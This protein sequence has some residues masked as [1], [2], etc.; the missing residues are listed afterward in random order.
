[1]SDKLVRLDIEDDECVCTYACGGHHGELREQ[2]E[3]VCT[4]TCQ[5]AQS[6]SQEDVQ[7]VRGKEYAL[8][9]KYCPGLEPTLPKYTYMSY[10]P[11]TSRGGYNIFA[12]YMVQGEVSGENVQPRRG[13]EEMKTVGQK[14]SFG[15]GDVSILIT[16]WEKRAGGG[17]GEENNGTQV[18]ERKERRVSQ[19]FQELRQKFVDNEE[20]GKSDLTVMPKSG[21]S[22]KHSNFSTISKFSTTQGRGAVRKICFKNIT[23]SSIVGQGGASL[24]GQTANRKRKGGELEE[25]KSESKR[26]C[27]NEEYKAR[28]LSTWT[29]Y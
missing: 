19:E 6:H 7:G 16:D 27:W 15:W 3:C 20:G 18:E 1:M 24:A 10:K 5:G 14:E 23:H 13:E 22:T 2:D 11:S 12:P 21:T 26:Y 9:I 29:N 17:E 8:G 28:N 4:F 25:S